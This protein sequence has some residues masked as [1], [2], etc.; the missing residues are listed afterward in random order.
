MAQYDLGRTGT[1]R[2]E[3]V[4]KPSNVIPALFGRLFTRQLDDS[5]YALPLIVSG[6]NVPNVGARNVL[7][8]ATMGNTVYAFDADDA[9]RSQPYWVRSV[10]TPGPGD[11]WIGPVRH[12][13]L[14]TPFIDIP[15]G[16]L[17]GVARTQTAAGVELRMFAL[18]IQ[19]GAFKYNSPQRMSFPAADSSPITNGPTLAQRPGLLVLGDVLYIANGGV[20]TNPSDIESQEG[21]LQ[22]FNARDLAQRIGSFQVTPTGLKGGIWQAG[23]GIAA[24]PAGNIYVSTAGADYDGMT[25]FGSS[26]LKFSPGTLTLLDWFTPAN[27]DYLFHNNIDVSGGG[28]IALPDTNFV[29]AGGKEGV[30]YLLDRS[31]MGKLENAQGQ[32]LQRFQASNGCGLTDCA[33]FLGTAYWG[34][35]GPGKLYVWDRNDVLRSYRFDGQRFETVPFATGTLSAGSTSGPSVSASGAD[36]GSGI[37]WAVTASSSDSG[38]QQPGTLRAFRATDVAQELYN[39]DVM[40]ARDAPGNF[41]KFAPPVVANGKVYVATQSNR[42]A[43]YGLLAPPPP[44][45]PIVVISAPNGGAPFSTSSAAVRLS[46]SATEAASLASIRFENDRGGSGT[47]PGSA[48][49]SFDVTLQSGLNNITVRATTLAGQTGSASIAITYNPPVLPPDPP[50]GNALRFVPVTP[51]RVADTRNPAGVLGG[52]VMAAGTIR[53]F[54]I[55]SGCGIP[56]GAL[57]YSLNVT[58]VPRGMLGY[59]T[60]WPTG[61]PPPVVSTL[62]SFDGRIKANAAI[63]PAGVGGAVS[64]YVTHTT[65]VVLDINGYFVPATDPAALTFYPLAPCRVADT[66]ETTRGLL[67]APAM[68]AGEVRTFPVL[69]SA[70]N[71]P[72]SARAY[73][74]N[75]TVVP[76]GALGY[77]TTWPAGQSQPYVSTL[78]AL[79]GT[80]T[81]NAAMVPAGN[82]GAISVFTTGATEV[83]I[84]ANGYFAPPGPG[85]LSLFN[86][87]PCRVLDTRQPSDGPRL[88]GT[89]NVIVSGSMCAVPAAARA[90]ALNATVVPPA[91]LGYLSLWPQGVAQPHVST[92]NAMDAAITSNMAIVPTTNGSISAFSP[93]PTD[94]ILDIS[95]YFAP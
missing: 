60:M 25:N 62:N 29:I 73:S 33:Q 54:P 83:I 1:N 72:A 76:R 8:V 87:L 4:L 78:N 30:V 91:S 46:G 44:V 95:G 15:T 61:S 50:S 80:V 43:V 55:R 68:S 13:I 88:N 40:S 39:S 41:T 65:D 57:A 28:V 64:I 69:S 74:F 75:F 37:V 5:V 82:G 52:P 47:V 6:V 18:D 84:D 92:L 81:A 31:T 21:F 24:D 86:L 34:Q 9:T 23:R 32:P 22:A 14:S 77:V 20:L 56:A 71:L 63:V 7:Y 79:T 42:I 67:G 36:A 3:I 35:Q 45:I 26:V 17:Y 11:A 27:H 59:L 90:Y 94:L 53:S 19:T 58:V 12:G 70:C 85:G 66:R 10:S 89:R 16:T 49:W 48:T 2:Q 93:S 51:C 38:A